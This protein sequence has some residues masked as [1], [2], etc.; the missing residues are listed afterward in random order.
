[1]PGYVSQPDEATFRRVTKDVGCAIIGQTSDL[2]PADKRFYGI[3]DVT[4]TVESVPLI[5]ASIL[6]KKLAAGL[7]GLVLDVKCG[8]GAFMDDLDK[9]RE[10]ATSLVQVANG[11]GLPATAL[12]TDMNAPLANA[13]G[14]AVEV[15]HA[16]DFLT[17]R[18]TDARLWDVTVALG[19]E[20]LVAGGLEPSLE[21][22][23]DAI[24]QAFLSGRAA[25]I[26][27]RM[28]VAL[29]GPSDL[30]E[31][32]ERHLPHAPVIRAVHPDVAGHVTGIAT[33]AVGYAVVALGGGRVRAE[34]DVDPRVGFTQ[35]A[36]IGDAVGPDDALGMVH[37]A[38]E[39]A[40]DRAEAALRA[41]YSLGE[42]RDVSVGDTIIERIS[43]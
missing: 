12:L 15:A 19:A 9:A 21:Y 17:G 37:A 3:R 10:L 29:G 14:N 28:V 22:A 11:A 40:A 18:E 24:A 8:N 31:K 42:A 26:F 7:G 4:A 6:S 38:D 5:T 33:R 13:A 2:A 20:M 27:A 34:D 36:Q 30:M 16:I 32:P 1:I 25:E 41:A 23:Q 35:L 39:D 43:G